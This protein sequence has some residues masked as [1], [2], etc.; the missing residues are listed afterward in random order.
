MQPR[1]S[2]VYIPIGAMVRFFFFVHLVYVV[3][4]ESS[5]EPRVWPIGESIFVHLYLSRFIMICR[6]IVFA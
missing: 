3:F 5:L 2:C 6:V 4:V 1:K